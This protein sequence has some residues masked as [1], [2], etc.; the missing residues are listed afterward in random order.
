M[1]LYILHA[2]THSRRVVGAFQ[3][4]DAG[5]K[6]GQHADKQADKRL[7]IG[8]LLAEQDIIF[9]E[10]AGLFPA[11]AL[12]CGGLKGERADRNELVAQAA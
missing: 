5:G 2:Q 1:G 12:L 9:I 6:V 11:E 8:D 7:L 4:L 3:R 10:P